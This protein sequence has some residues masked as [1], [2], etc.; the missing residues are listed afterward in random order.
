MT[1]HLSA[2][3]ISFGY[4]SKLVLRGIDVSVREGEIVSL[5]G[6]NGTGKSTLLK[7]LLGILHPSGGQVFFRGKRLREF[8]RR[9]LA[10]EIAYVP[11]I[12]RVSFPYRVIDVVLMGRIPSK[13][14]IV[15]YSR[16]D[17][18]I[19][20]SA[21]ERLSIGHLADRP[22]TEISG[23]ERQLTL[24][25]R[26]MA[27]GAETFIMDEPASGLDYGNQIRLLEQIRSLSGQ[28]YTFV[29]STHFPDHALWVAE[30]VV[31]LKDGGVAAEG[32]PFE[33]INGKNLKM[34]YGIDVEVLTV[35][36]GLRVCVPLGIG[37]GRGAV[38]SKPERDPS[39]LDPGGI[40]LI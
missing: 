18:K 1:D 36:D 27:Q 5:L 31:M 8:D 34:L 39:P 11:Q 38:G 14:F 15:S 2:R 25:A 24:I 16:Q 7:I 32:T 20:R 22:Y 13:R 17:G 6:P 9:V 28:G 19:A 23:G 26:A 33:V 21:L 40:S 29:K 3:D 35:S 12:H 37:N 4:T 10:G 30:R